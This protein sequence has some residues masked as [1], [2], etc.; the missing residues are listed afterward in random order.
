MIVQSIIQNKAIFLKI[1]ILLCSFL[2]GG[3]GHVYEGRGWN[4]QGA[5]TQGF[6]TKGYGVCFIGNF[7][8]KNPT[9]AAVDAFHSL[10]K[11]R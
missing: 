9:Q 10:A 4:V 7:M 5:H 6:N 8:E 3:D 2:I 1:L 11:V